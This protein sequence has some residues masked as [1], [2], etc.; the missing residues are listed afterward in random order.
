MFFIWE[1]L[2]RFGNFLGNILEILLLSFILVLIIVV[3]LPSIISDWKKKKERIQGEGLA[4]L[5]TSPR[6][7]AKKFK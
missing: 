7:M 4:E 5:M 1:T 3:K 2:K 6:N